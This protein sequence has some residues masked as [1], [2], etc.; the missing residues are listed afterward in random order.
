MESEDYQP[1]ILMSPKKGFA[2]DGETVSLV[3]VHVETLKG[4]YDL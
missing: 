3:Q 4:T 1:R 2:Y